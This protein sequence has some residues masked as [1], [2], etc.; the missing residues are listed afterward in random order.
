VG[1]KNKKYAASLVP[2]RMLGSKPDN[3]YC[4]VSR[5]LAL[6]KARC[7]VRFLL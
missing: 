3:S 6:L 7:L 4:D 1:E 5:P 2:L